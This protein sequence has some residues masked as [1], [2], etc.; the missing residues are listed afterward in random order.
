[1]SCS[2]KH[3]TPGRASS[4]PSSHLTRLA[5]A[6]SAVSQT[7]TNR[8]FTCTHA[9][10]QALPYSFL[11]H[12]HRH[13]DPRPARPA[14]SN[15]KS[16]TRGPNPHGSQT[17]FSPTATRPSYPVLLHLAKATP[18]STLA[19]HSTRQPTWSSAGRTKKVYHQSSKQTTGLGANSLTVPPCA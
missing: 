7:S 4:A 18:A 3:P 17:L 15:P 16:Q 8:S 1:M 19:T 12:H 9:I 13:P 5:F 6:Q 14:R 10:F 2:E 11:L